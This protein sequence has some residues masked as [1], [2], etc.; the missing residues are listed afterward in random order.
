[1]APN[2]PTTGTPTQD[3]GDAAEHAPTT[4]TPAAEGRD[5][6]SQTATEEQVLAW[7]AKAE[8]ANKVPGLMA[9]IDELEER[10]AQSPAAPGD[11][12]DDDDDEVDWDQVRYHASR[13]DATAKAQLKQQKENAE[14]RAELREMQEGIRLLRQL[15][16]IPDKDEQKEVTKHFKQNRHRL[17]DINA[18]RAEIR[19]KKLEVENDELRKQLAA[20]AKKPPSG[21]TTGEREVPASAM[22]PTEMTRADWD[23]EQA[24]FPDTPEGAKDR[25]RRQREMNKK[26]VLVKGLNA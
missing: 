22:K 6:G 26:L 18:A 4:G 14:L 10:Q 9:R 17:G 7:K 8:E 20:A 15:D 2:A 12:P 24:S 3:G 11:E 5:A 16:A 19:E 13:G 25:M 23:A 1:M 21:P